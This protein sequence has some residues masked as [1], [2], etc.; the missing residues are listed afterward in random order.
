MALSVLKARPELPIVRALALFPTLHS[1]AEQSGGVWYLTRPLV[2]PLAA[3]FAGLVTSF[4]VWLL[5]TLL[6]LFAPDDELTR[7]ILKANVTYNVGNN[8]LYLAHTELDQV[9][10]FDE[11]ILRDY[12]ERLFF[13]YGQTDEWV[14]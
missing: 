8:C 5:D 6:G 1:M 7:A 10:D 11:S 9:R 3:G 2:R 4:P 14:S 13:L 12:G